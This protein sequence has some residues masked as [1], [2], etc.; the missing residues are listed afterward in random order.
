[1][2]LWTWAF[3]RFDLLTGTARLERQSRALAKRRRE[4]LAV[5]AAAAFSGL[6]SEVRFLQVRFSSGL[7]KNELV[8]I[9]VMVSMFAE[10]R[11]PSREVKRSVP[12][13]IGW[14]R[15]EWGRVA[16]WL[17]VMQ[18]RDGDDQP[19]DSS[20]ELSDKGVHPKNDFQ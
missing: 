3:V 8:S 1:V 11:P 5:L 14:F 7:R 20:R 4:K 10:I 6:C 15:S 18:L 9:A 13:L 19:I 17:A 16:P 2:W 12:A